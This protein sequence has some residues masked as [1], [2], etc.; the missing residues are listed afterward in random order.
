MASKFLELEITE[1][2]VMQNVELAKKVLQELQQMGICIAMDDFGTGYSSLS[3]IKQFPLN[4]V[5]I[6]RTF[7]NDLAIDPYDRAIA[8]AVISLGKSLNLSIVAEG[9]ETN[10]QLNCLQLL[11][12]PQIQGYL[13]S[14]P[15]SA[16]DATALLQNPPIEL[17]KSTKQ[18]L[19]G[20]NS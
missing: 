10:E 13:F 6:D 11:K 2:T 19:I 3:Y 16:R 5:K 20:T 8:Q 4:T 17:V 15:L 9:V 1:T 12:C 7:I 18:G 14:R